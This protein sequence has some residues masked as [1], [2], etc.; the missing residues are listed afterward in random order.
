MAIAR[1]LALDPRPVVCDEPVSAVD[2]LVRDQ[3]LGLP[4]RPQEEL[5]LGTCSSPT[6]EQ[7]VPVPG[8]TVADTVLP[9]L[10]DSPNRRFVGNSSR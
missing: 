4:S 7:T 6:D 10:A 8:T 2:V 5:G 3:L 9:H 1:A